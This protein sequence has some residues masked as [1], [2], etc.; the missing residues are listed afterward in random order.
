M[1]IA[2]FLTPKKDVIWL[3]QR[4]TLRQAIERMEHH[5]VPAVPVLDRTGHYVYT[6][7]EGDVLWALKHAPQL[8]FSG[9]ENLRLFSLPRRASQQAVHIDSHMDQLLPGALDQYFVPVVDEREVF[10]GLVVRRDLIRYCLTEHALPNPVGWLRPSNLS[11]A[12]CGVGGS[13]L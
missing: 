11:A 6:L 2:F 3:P 7:T 12:A 5:A 13:P 1:N 10:I 9:T 8:S 4:A